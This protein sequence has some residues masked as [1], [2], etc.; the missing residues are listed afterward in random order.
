MSDPADGVSLVDRSPA[1][2]TEYLSKGGNKIIRKLLRP[3]KE[4]SWTFYLGLKDK[5]ENN[6]SV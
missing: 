1:P 6:R 4:G 2:H 5:D 3:W